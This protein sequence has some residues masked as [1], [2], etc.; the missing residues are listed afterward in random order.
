MNRNTTPKILAL[1]IAVIFIIQNFFALAQTVPIKIGVLAHKGIEECRT[2]WQP[3]IDYLNTAIPEKKFEL[4]PLTFQNINEATARH[5]IDFVICNPGMYV[6][7]EYK[8][9][10]SRMLTYNHYVDGHFL[11]IFGGVIFTRQNRQ[12]IRTLHDIKGKKV[13]AVEKRSFGGWATG[14]R[15]LI[16]QGID[17]D[18]DFADLSFA[19]TQQQVVLNV[20]NNLAD[21]GFI[22]TGILEKL[23]D[24]GKIKLADFYVMPPPK[25]FVDSN[26]PLLHS[27]RL[28]PE[29]A[30]AKLNTTPDTLATSIAIALLSL[31]PQNS[32][33]QTE[34]LRK[35]TISL[36][37]QT[38][39]ACLQEIKFTPY[40][41]YGEVTLIDVFN[42]YFYW[43]IFSVFLIGLLFIM[44]ILL[45]IINRKSSILMQQLEDDIIQ[46]KLIEESLQKSE[47]KFRTVA[48]YTY[49]WEYWENEN[50]QIVYISPSCEM[51]SGYSPD[52]FVA[53]PKLL[54]KVVHP[55]DTDILKRHLEETFHEKK[56]DVCDLEFRIVK[57]DG[58]IEYINHVCRPIFNDDKK[59]C[60]RRVSH[61]KITERKLA[62]EIILQKNEE[63]AELNAAKDKFFSII[64]HDLRNPLGNFRN[65]TKLLAESYH[66]FSE[67]NRLEFL[68]VMKDSANNI[69]SLLENLLEWSRSQRGMIQFNPVELNIKMLASEVIELVKPAADKKQITIVNNIS[70]KII[71]AADPNL[72]NTVYRNLV[73]NAVKFTHHGG[74][75]ELGVLNIPEVSDTFYIKDTGLGMDENIM[76]NLFKI[77]K[78]VSRPGTDN[79]PSTG[80]GLILCKDFVEK[81]GGKIWAESEE[82]KGSTFYFTLSKL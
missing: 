24:E 2:S 21:V 67:K 19:E 50:H 63:L 74:K 35:W 46:R 39:H 44:S 16:N 62:D 55:E 42:K 11:N 49:D 68:G 28:Y 58:T 82:S 17:P 56:D 52:E 79:E 5:D 38:V 51:I 40:E 61:R 59:Y 37:Y 8:Y 43:I 10:V 45:V 14:L 60:G 54:Q 78:D 1:L 18:K 81:H 65:I 22:R 23:N 64:A 7:L 41:K 34:K 30:F 47:L 20:L 6:E 77:D 3:T 31:N 66:E 71:V 80:L 12:D 70:E 25:E 32:P 33:I 75:I 9:R 73:S 53:N 13:C 15:E 57:K 48:D 72:L 76:K 69:F 26:F 29:W 4:V 36:S 27:T